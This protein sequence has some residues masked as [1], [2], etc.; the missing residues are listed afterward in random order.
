MSEI[1]WFPHELWAVGDVGE[2]SRVFL[3][4]FSRHDLTTMLRVVYTRAR[5]RA[6]ATRLYINRRTPTPIYTLLPTPTYYFYWGLGGSS[7]CA[8]VIHYEHDKTP[9]SRD[10]ELCVTSHR[11]CGFV[12]NSFTEFIAPNL[13]YQQARRWKSAKTKTPTRHSSARCGLHQNSHPTAWSQWWR[14]ASKPLERR[15]NNS[16]R[17]QPRT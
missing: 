5:A 11:N 2:C 13:S 14:D 10:A 7:S 15:C 3:C 12:H 8:R 9:E 16:I 6:R 1:V 17:P 4:P